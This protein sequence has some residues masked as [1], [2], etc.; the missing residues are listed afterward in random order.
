MPE[1]VPVSQSETRILMR[2]N[3]G[4]YQSAVVTEKT[5]APRIL[6]MKHYIYLSQRFLGN[7]FFPVF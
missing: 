2:K 4:G 3:Q 1:L 7:T 5:D 6:A